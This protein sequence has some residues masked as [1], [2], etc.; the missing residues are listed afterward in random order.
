MKVWLYQHYILAFLTWPLLIYDFPLSFAE[1]LQKSA[2]KYLKKWLKI[3]QKAD[4]SILYRSRRNKGL[5]LCSTTK[6][7]KRSQGTKAHLIKHSA[8]PNMLK[9]HE[10]KLDLDQNSQRDWKPTTALEEA[11]AEVDFKVRFQGQQGKSGLGLTPV[12]RPLLIQGNIV[13]S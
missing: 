8:D 6:C 4:V 9:L 1:D 2:N 11:E 7:L 3:N 13:N 12:K 10:F 5:Q